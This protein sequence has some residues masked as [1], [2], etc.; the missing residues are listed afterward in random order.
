[1]TE[2]N[3]PFVDIHTH[4]NGKRGAEQISIQ[5]IFIQDFEQNSFEIPFSVGWHPWD[6][7]KVE[8]VNW[9]EFLKS[10][11]NESDL[12]AIGESGLDKAI[13]V[14]LDFQK[15]IFLKHIELSEELKK[16]LIIHCVRAYSEILEIRKSS[17]AQM[18]W[19]IHGFNA[20]IQI[21]KQCIQKGII[22][23]FGAFLFNEKTKAFRTIRE[24]KGELFFLETDDQEKYE[25]KD[26]YNQVAQIHRI[27]LEEL[28]ENIYIT[29]KRLFDL[30]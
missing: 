17:K 18:P 10:I 27:E 26:I 30:S 21:A 24:L 5:N 28:K 9:N 15:E 13:E 11:E 29:F 8:K 6:Y 1:M 3:Y 7:N 16:P 25:I 12:L 4:F 19:I 23:S 22:P 2:T 20:N 14:S